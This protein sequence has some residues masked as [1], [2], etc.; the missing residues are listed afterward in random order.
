MKNLTLFQ[1]SGSSRIIVDNF[2]IDNNYKIKHVDFI[3]TPRTQLVLYKLQ[4]CIIQYIECL[5]ED[6]KLVSISFC[7]DSS[8]ELKY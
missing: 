2:M 1:L 4:S 7:N 6:N 3:D 8:I 5:F